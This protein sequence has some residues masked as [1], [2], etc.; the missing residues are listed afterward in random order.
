MDIYPVDYTSDVGRVRKYVPDIIPLPDPKD[1]LSDPTYM[2]SDEAIQSFIDDDIPPLWVV[3]VPAPRSAI[4][5]AAANIMIATANNEN[6]ILKKL[7]TEDLETDG[8]A[9]AKALL[10]SAQELRKKAD[11]DDAAGEVEEVFFTVPYVHT[12]PRYVLYPPYNQPWGQV[13]A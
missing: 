2:W 3:G 6:L 11:A 10:L 9:V 5:R 12:P 7:V 13:Y 4:W 8:P 1:P